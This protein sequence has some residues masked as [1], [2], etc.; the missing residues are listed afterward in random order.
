MSGPL[1]LLGSLVP[2]SKLRELGDCEIREADDGG[3]ASWA[4]GFAAAPGGVGVWVLPSWGRLVPARGP[5]GSGANLTAGAG[6][7]SAIAATAKEDRDDGPIVPAAGAVKAG[8]DIC[9]ELAAPGAGG[10]GLA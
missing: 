7:L 9:G 10:T 3:L 2:P 8:P 6:G 4:E 5:D 1:E